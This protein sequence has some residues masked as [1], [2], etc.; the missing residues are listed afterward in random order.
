MRLLTR[1][2]K[3]KISNWWW[4][5][6]KVNFSLALFL[7]FI[8][9]MLVLSA[10]PSAAHRDRLVDEFS[11]VKKQGVFILAGIGLMIGVSMQNL[12]TI[13]RLAVFGFLCAFVGV[14]LTYIVGDATKGAARWIKF[15]GF[16]L[17]PSEFIKP[18][19]I[20]V[21]AWLLDANK[22]TDDFPGMTVSVVL[23]VITAGAV[24]GQPDLGM[25]VLISG[26]WALQ[27][28]WAGIP[29]WLISILFTLGA[30]LVTGSYFFLAHVRDRIDRF[31]AT[32]NE[33][34][35]QIQKSM[36][37]FANGNLLGRGPGEGVVKMSLPDVH[38][39][40]IFS[41]AGEEYGVWLTSLIVIS[42]AVIVVRTML[43][44]LKDN[45]LFQM[46][47]ASGLAASL[48]GQAIV[49]MCSSLQLMPAKGMTLPF[50]SYGGSSMLAS[51]L[52][53]GMLLAITR[54]NAVSED[55]DNG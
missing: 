2:S 19:F 16:S 35:S 13:R 52:T 33:I 44:S 24:F 1:H 22:R 6:D 40:F 3:S 41:L 5:V 43:N 32:E 51:C 34:G 12:R 37:A 47:A 48:G 14:V 25:T 31:L 4:T 15:A 38:T 49:N 21:T 26:V 17:Q 50:V 7:I 42:F 9:V 23:Y 39:D 28:V 8:G 10:S 36:D 11:F 53:M 27:M 45:N 46:Y 20:V 54:K 29:A 18:V 55:K 30:V